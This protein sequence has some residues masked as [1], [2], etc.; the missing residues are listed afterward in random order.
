MRRNKSGN[1]QSKEMPTSQSTIP[2]PTLIS[3]AHVIPISSNKDR[4]NLMKKDNKL[5]GQRKIPVPSAN[6]FASR[7][8][9]SRTSLVK[10]SEDDILK[11]EKQDTNGI[12][13]SIPFSSNIPNSNKKSNNELVFND[14]NE[15]KHP[16]SDITNGIN[17]IIQNG[18]KM[19]IA[20]CGNQANGKHQILIPKYNVITPNVRREKDKTQIVKP[21]TVTSG[22]ATKAF[23]SNDI[24]NQRQP[25][26]KV[27]RTAVASTSSLQSNNFSGN[28]CIGKEKSALIKKTIP[29]NIK[30][31]I[32]KTS[33]RYIG[34]L[35]EPT[36]SIS[37]NI[38][39]KPTSNNNILHRAGGEMSKASSC[40]RKVEK[41]DTNFKMEDKSLPINSTLKNNNLKATLNCDTT[42]E[43]K[44]EDKLRDLNETSGWDKGDI[45][46]CDKNI[47]EDDRK[48]Y[49]DNTISHNY[50]EVPMDKEIKTVDEKE[51]IQNVTI[52]KLTE[53]GLTEIKTTFRNSPGEYNEIENTSKS[54]S[55]YSISQNTST[56]PSTSSI[57]GLPYPSIQEEEKSFTT[58]N[59]CNE[60][61]FDSKE[62]HLPTNSN[63][64][65]NNKC[66][67]NTTNEI[68]NSENDFINAQ[69]PML[70]SPKIM[71]RLHYE[72]NNYSKINI[73][74]INDENW[75]Y[76]KRKKEFYNNNA[77]TD[78]L[79]D[80]LCRDNR[81]SKRRS[82]KSNHYVNFSTIRE[83]QKNLKNDCI[84]ED[85]SSSLSSDISGTVDISSSEDLSDSSSPDFSQ[86][87]P[88]SPK[89]IYSCNSR[90][91]TK[92]HIMTEKERMNELLLKSRT[93]HRSSAYTN[94]SQAIQNSN[95][96]LNS[97]TSLDNTPSLKYPSS[98]IHLNYR[99][100]IKPSQLNYTLDHGYSN[101]LNQLQVDGYNNENGITECRSLDRVSCTK[102][103]QKVE[104]N[105]QNQLH[106]INLVKNDVTERS[107]KNG[108]GII[109]MNTVRQRPASCASNKRVPYEGNYSSL[110]SKEN[111]Y[112]SGGK[113]DGKTSSSCHAKFES[114]YYNIL[115]E[116]LEQAIL[117]LEHLQFKVEPM[118]FKI[119]K[120]KDQLKRLQ[121]YNSIVQKRKTMEENMLPKHSSVESLSSIKSKISISGKDGNVL[122]SK[123][124]GIATTIQK[125]LTPHSS[126]PFKKAFKM[127]KNKSNK[128]DIEIG[129]NNE[130]LSNETVN[131]KSNLIEKDKQLTEMRLEAL[132]KANEVEEL[133]ETIKK[134]ECENLSL[135]IHS[136]INSDRSSSGD[137]TLS[138][139]HN[140][141]NSGNLNINNNSLTSNGKPFCESEYRRVFIIN[142]T[143][144]VIHCNDDCQ[145]TFIGY[146][147]APN[148][149]L[150]WKLFDTNI[151][152]I[153]K[154]YI[155]LMDNKGLLG[156]NHLSSILGYS[157]GIFKRN[158]N[159]ISSSPSNPSLL[160][161]SD[162]KIHLFL[163][164]DKQKCLDSLVF[165][166]FLT[167]NVLKML[168]ESIEKS[169]YILVNGDISSIKEI[170][171]T[172][173]S[174]KFKDTST[175]HCII[176]GR[177]FDICRQKIFE[178]IDKVFNASYKSKTIIVIIHLRTDEYNY[179]S[180]KLQRRK[181]KD[182]N[183][184]VLCC[185]EEG[186]GSN[187][188]QT[189]NVFTIFNISDEDEILRKVAQ[190][191][192][193]N[194]QN[195]DDF[196]ESSNDDIEKDTRQEYD[197]VI[198][199]LVSIYKELL[200]FFSHLPS[201]K[202]HSL[203]LCKFLSPPSTESRKMICWF[204]NLWNEKLVPYSRECIS[205]AK[206]SPLTLSLI[207]EPLNVVTR[208]WPWENNTYPK[209]LLTSIF[210]NQTN[211]N[212]YTNNIDSSFDPLAALIKLQN[213]NNDNGRR[214][215]EFDV[216]GNDKD[217][218]FN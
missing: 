24:M 204:S 180:E 91:Y 18:S 208:E 164:G 191:N 12:S 1:S 10:S 60:N 157:I 23:I 49:D 62:K 107:D 74:E 141:W 175:K 29:S 103:K 85:D 154:K 142:D 35:K 202:T 111:K 166:T 28:N 168:I 128:D 94:Y 89:S 201:S 176:N 39:T 68:I 147:K 126:N 95:G 6:V 129:K 65:I 2:Q 159:S 120:V 172:Q 78:K 106:S 171:I 26:I 205:K 203:L 90:T 136:T 70:T 161:T 101:N 210:Q 132:N 11:K 146:L 59:I 174:I 197:K 64:L 80:R 138:S 88:L 144:G 155:N 185:L 66:E 36:I 58:T 218:C 98:T 149:N 100:Q 104:K 30:K 139:T 213:C 214:S 217:F 114:N 184:Y 38:E 187:I 52:N 86:K 79:V 163:K 145:K 43:N 135:K 206:H 186:I 123:L 34:I 119:R 40:I 73:K 193:L 115:D 20:V 16:K 44:M 131:L 140:S 97:G 150:S 32:T 162:K 4:F 77:E 82:N 133:K 71:A 27:Q 108:H 177:E 25:L 189:N 195:P 7:S 50:D 167:K 117:E 87:P 75:N 165:N 199:F 118:D 113:D 130:D 215:R 196:I 181:I 124:S 116:E 194:L 151:S 21:I 110:N 84:L 137:F 46:V 188:Q 63:L 19:G 37:S 207:E 15:K 81:L 173:V 216:D 121:V 198:K 152:E 8:A 51:V 13:S 105:N 158:I 17:N 53:D 69:L 92:R 76:M 190:R 170:L 3:H 5:V 99:Y 178:E 96:S 182:N 55:P 31:P 42:N 61:T 112:F 9:L 54:S 148:N 160:C 122:K 156:L 41:V 48:M 209:N 134:L 127:K 72:E 14:N 67:K 83:Y 22:T 200:N 57:E 102:K 109:V 93:S 183:L 125:T 212:F 45:K 143:S 169:K 56:S 153:F 33:S 192:L 211:Q 47:N 179:I